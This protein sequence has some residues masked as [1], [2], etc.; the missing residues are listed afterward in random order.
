MNGN[1]VYH[2]IGLA[3]AT[4][5]MAPMPAA[6]RGWVPPW[7]RKKYAAGVRLR[8]WALLCLY[9]NIL[10]NGIPRLADASYETVMAGY[11]STQKI[12]PI[13]VSI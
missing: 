4:A 9:G 7:Q 8:A 2:W 11:P 5:V 13:S 3:I 6:M 12:D 10:A 1:P